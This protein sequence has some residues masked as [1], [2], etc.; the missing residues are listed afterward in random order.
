MHN[1][2]DF[3]QNTT[4]S[5]AIHLAIQKYPD[6][7]IKDESMHISF[8]ELWRCS[9]ALAFDLKSKGVVEGDKVAILIKNS[10][11]YIVSYVAIQILGAIIIPI[12]VNTSPEELVNF[13]EV[14]N[15]NFILISDENIPSVQ[16]MDIPQ[17]RVNNSDLKSY[18]ERLC[19]MFHPLPDQPAFPAIFLRTS[20]TTGTPKYVVH[21]HSSLLNNAIAHSVSIQ[22][23]PNDIGLIVLPMPFGYCN[24]AQILAYILSGI[25]IV[26]GGS[27]LLLDQLLELVEHYQITTT[28]VVPSILRFLHKHHDVYKNKIGTLRQICFGGAVCNKQFLEDLI[29]FYPHIEFVQTYGMTEAGPRATTWSSLRHPDT[30]GSVGLP[31]EGVQVFIVPNKEEDSASGIGEVYISSPYLMQRYYNDEASTAAIL[32]QG[33]LRTGD[34]GYIDDNGFLYLVGRQKNI[35][36]V[37]GINVAPEEI[38]AVLTQHP[39]VK[40]CLVYSAP[41]LLLGERIE[42]IIVPYE[43]NIFKIFDLKEFCKMRLPKHKVPVRFITSESLEKTSTGKVR[44]AKYE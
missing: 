9:N 10:I 13:R 29:R 34:L 20:G 6:R 17:L 36:I 21:N 33:K 41:D 22:I 1:N 40:E 11:T 24:T 27:T 25:S 15:P 8:S 7:F 18:L 5:R 28:T 43:I 3:Y 23:C 31:I 4:L 37:G 16:G 39:S 35:I 32:N 42:A 38:E 26:I 2:Y 30:A 14:I 44:R 12:S 19:D